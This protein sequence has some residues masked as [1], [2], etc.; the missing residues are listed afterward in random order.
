[1]ADF[2]VRGADDFLRASKALKAAGQTEM[3]KQF[4]KD[5]KAATKPLIRKAKAAAKS[6]LPSGLAKVVGAAPITAK[7]KTG[8]DPGVTVGVGKKGGGAAATNRG[9]VRHPVFGRQ[10]SWVEQP[11][12]R[13]KDWFDGTMRAGTPEVR[14]EM[15]QTVGRVLDNIAEDARR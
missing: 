8:R 10:N 11:V 12:P 6:Q 7:V 14:R 15:E 9:T 5:M 4:H 3:R 2:E 1:M 13:A